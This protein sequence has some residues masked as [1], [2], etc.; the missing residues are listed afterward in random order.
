MQPAGD[1]SSGAEILDRVGDAQPQDR[2]V[3]IA[4]LAPLAGE[5]KRGHSRIGPALRDDVGGDLPY[6][7]LATCH[8]FATPP[9]PGRFRRPR[10]THGG[11]WG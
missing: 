7:P 4:L 6:S 1:G 11:K 5:K 8:N 2:A 3:V 10:A 9:A